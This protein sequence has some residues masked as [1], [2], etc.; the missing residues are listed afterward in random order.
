MKRALVAGSTGLVG[1]ELLKQLIAHPEYERIHILVRKPVE[2][3]SEKVREHVI[4]F[5]EIA[6][7]SPPEQVDHV[8]CTLGTTI[9]K[10][11]TREKFS[12]VDHDYVVALGSL[13][14]EWKA[15]K[16]LVVTA[17]GAN[18]GSAIFYNRVK[19][20]T[21]RDLA[22]LDLPQLHI[23][24]PSLLMGD[25]KENRAGEK[26]AIAVYKVINPLFVGKLKKYKG[27][28]AAQVAGAMISVALQHN[29]KTS[30]YE[31][32]EIQDL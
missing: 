1:S 7:F 3:A 8:F 4:D 14:K 23:F 20:E 28:Q 9:K 25:R 22:A 13:A 18:A 12:T 5:N 17:L 31:S 29:N 6:S 19:G 10:A 27:I 30:V 11:G 21:E 26:T 32:N 16:F 2:I 24:R 15:D